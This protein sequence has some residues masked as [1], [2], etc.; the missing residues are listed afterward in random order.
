MSDITDLERRI[1]AALGRIEATVEQGLATSAE[2]AADTSEVDA[3]REAL[4]AEKATNAQLEERVKVIRE[5]QDTT[6]AELEGRVKRLRERLAQQ[7]NDVQ[8]L[9]QVNA[10]LRTSNDAL[11]AAN[12]A[13]VADEQLINNAMLAEL[14]SLRATQSA[15]RSE[16]DAVLNELKPI[17]QEDA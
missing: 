12:E 17:I 5:K 2:P 16:L 8:R 6:F 4:E 11:R 15:D 10:E 14:E 7:E 13:G 1:T 9:K 3:L